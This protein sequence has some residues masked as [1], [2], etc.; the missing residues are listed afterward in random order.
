MARLCSDYCTGLIDALEQQQ[1]TLLTLGDIFTKLNGRRYFSQID[2]AE[3]Y[4]QVEVEQ[5]S[6]PLLTIH[7][8]KGLYYV[9]HLP[10]GVKAAP[11]IF[12]FLFSFALPVFDL[13]C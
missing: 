12:K 10:F 4:L 11:G 6:R 9:N 13:F 7:T 2:L 1:H 8:H 3:A 5:G